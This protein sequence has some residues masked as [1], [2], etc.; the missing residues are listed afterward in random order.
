MAVKKIMNS[1]SRREGLLVERKF[2]GGKLVAKAIMKDHFPSKHVRRRAK[3]AHAAD[4]L[5]VIGLTEAELAR[6]DDICA[7]STVITEYVL[8]AITSPWKSSAV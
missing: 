7:R 5:E 1:G 6:I 3:V 2:H 8:T 4:E